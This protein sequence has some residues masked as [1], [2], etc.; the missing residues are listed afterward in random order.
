MNSVR[1][2][3]VFQA[4]HPPTIQTTLDSWAMNSTAGTAR[5][6]RRFVK[7]HLVEMDHIFEILLRLVRGDRVA[8]ATAS[9]QTTTPTSLTGPLATAVTEGSHYAKSQNHVSLSVLALLR[10]THELAE[11]A[12][13]KSAVVD[14]RVSESESSG[15]HHFQVYLP[16]LR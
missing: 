16:S 12:G 10:L 2:L 1:F 7:T 6:R 14:E 4:S 13:V 15:S 9:Q 11:K 8:S 5:E 3:P